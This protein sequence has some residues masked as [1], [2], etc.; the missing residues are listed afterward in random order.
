MEKEE[1][2]VVEDITI[3][4]VDGEEEVIEVVEKAKTKKMEDSREEI[5]LLDKEE[6]EAKELTKKMNS[7]KQ[8]NN[9]PKIKF[10]LKNK[11]FSLPKK[12]I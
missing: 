9:L 8:M 2:E 10:S 4:E 11:N 6:E 12:T 5:D 3:I 1:A 7:N